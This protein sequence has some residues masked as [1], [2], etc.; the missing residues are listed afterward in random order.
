[1]EE[2]VDLHRI[3]GRLRRLGVSNV[4][5]VTH[6]GECARL[7]LQ[8]PAKLWTRGYSIQE[9]ER[10]KTIEPGGTWFSRCSAEGLEKLWDAWAAAD[11]FLLDR[12]TSGPSR[13]IWILLQL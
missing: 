9:G 8:Q 7:D 1:M 5:L 13:M 11:A 3:E 6:T 4:K 12:I 2:V 10:L